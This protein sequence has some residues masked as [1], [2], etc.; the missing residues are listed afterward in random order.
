MV[1]ILTHTTDIPITMIGEMAGICWGSNTTD[2]EKNF[3]RGI[4]CIRN[5]HGRTLEFP[6]IYMEISGYSARVI[7]EFYTHIGGLPTRLQES[8]R[9]VDLGN[10]EYVVP[11]SVKNSNCE[12]TYLNLMEMITSTEQELENNGVPKE[13]AAMVYP[14]GMET[15]IVWKGNLR[16]L[17]DMAKVRTC[18]RAYWEFRKLFKE[19][20]DSL[21]FYSDEWKILIEFEKVFKCKCEEFGYCNEKFSCNRYPK[22][23]QQYYTYEDYFATQRI[24]DI[25]LK[26]DK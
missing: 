7:R 22:K 23:N 25:R 5:N 21:S 8:T 11:P 24:E 20:K 18:N 12:N 4:E 17:I 9:Y 13:D 14:L 10:F 2:H 15:K 26:E 6:D 16:T 3:K 19:I 1:R